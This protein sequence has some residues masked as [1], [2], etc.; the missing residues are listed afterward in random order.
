MFENVRGKDVFVHISAVQRS[1]LNGLD[2]GQKVNYE[3]V[4]DKRTG[5]FLTN[6]QVL[7]RVVDPLNRAL[8][9]AGDKEASL[10]HGAHFTMGAEKGGYVS[11]AKIAKI[12]DPGAVNVFT[13]SG[14]STTSPCDCSRRRGDCSPNGSTATGP[15]R[16]RPKPSMWCSHS[17]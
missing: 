15:T 16:S 4:K 12:G 5:R 13:G 3:I 9:A 17:S 10:F 1:G 8:M 2:E 14:M 7:D 6:E 11:N